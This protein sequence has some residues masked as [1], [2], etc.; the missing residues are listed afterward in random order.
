MKRRPNER[1]S[2]AALLGSLTLASM[3]LGTSAHAD[4]TSR[5]LTLP[6]TVPS[7]QVNVLGKK[8]FTPSL[9]DLTLSI[10]VDGA[11]SAPTPSLVNPAA[12]DPGFVPLIGLGLSGGEASVESA[13]V[14]VSGHSRD[15]TGTPTRF[16]RTL[17]YSPGQTVG[18]VGPGALLEICVEGFVPPSITTTEHNDSPDPGCNGVL[19]TV[20][21]AGLALYLDNRN[22][23]EALINPWIYAETNGQPGLQRG[24]SNPLG[25]SEPCPSSSATP[26]TLIL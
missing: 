7:V 21:V 18:P 22:P 4:V 8:L 3:L 14:T 24:G 19:T 1:R 23:G 11:I 16:E 26:D 9:R 2:M 17:T 20:Q 12:C 6:L 15:V 25:D 10:S 13:A 5:T